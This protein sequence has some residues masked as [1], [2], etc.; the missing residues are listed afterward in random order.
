[1]LAYRLVAHGVGGRT[2]R[3]LNEGE[4]ARRE[5]MDV[6]EF[7]TWAAFVSLEPFPEARAD[8]HTAML[9]AQTYNM[10]RGKGKPAKSPAEFMPQWHRS[11]RV[12]MTLEQQGAALRAQFVAMG[13]DLAQL[14]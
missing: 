8:A 9:M 14:E 6:D 2:V 3:E 5:G 7:L 10:N 13:G 4:E 1:M 12:E 11:P